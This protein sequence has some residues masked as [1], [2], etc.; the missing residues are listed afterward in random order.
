MKDKIVAVAIE[1]QRGS[2]TRMLL[3][4]VIYAEILTSAGIAH[5]EN[6]MLR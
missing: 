6:Q 4:L 5:T 1:F 2:V 3:F